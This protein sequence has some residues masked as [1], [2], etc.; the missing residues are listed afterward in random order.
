MNSFGFLA[1]LYR[2]SFLPYKEDG[3]EHIKYFLPENGTG[4]DIGA[5]I[6]RF[7]R[8]LAGLVGKK[9]LILSIEPLIY[10]RKIL[11]SMVFINRLNQ[12]KIL[13]NALS[14][15]EGKAFMNIP[16]KNGKPQSALA[17]LGATKFKESMSEEVE[18][19]T[20]DY[21][22]QEMNLRD[23]NFIKCDVE[24]LE[25]E[26]FKGAKEAIEK[27]KPTIFCEVTENFYS[28]NGR[29]SSIFFKLMSSY[30]Y[31]IFFPFKGKLKKLDKTNKLPTSV[32]D[33]FFIFNKKINS[34]DK[35]L[36]L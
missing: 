6:G 10:P 24:G 20:L 29:S 34:I 36:F 18:I 1:R 4:I 8:V 14:N 3:I 21:L 15:K 16:L 13:A 27:F 19:I 30:G 23:L 22:V 17:T 25:L 35:K 2:S 12:V 5:N 28:A 33:Y 9:G 31:K 7:T 32:Q 26:V 11:S